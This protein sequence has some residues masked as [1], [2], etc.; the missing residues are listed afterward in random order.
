MCHPIRHDD[1]RGGL[2]CLPEN[3]V[4]HLDLCQMSIWVGLLEPSCQASP[5]V[6]IEIAEEGLPDV[7]M[8]LDNPRQPRLNPTG[9][10]QSETEVLQDEG[11]NHRLVWVDRGSEPLDTEVC[12]ADQT[13]V[14]EIS[15]VPRLTIDDAATSHGVPAGASASSLRRPA[16]AS[17]SRRSPSFRASA[18]AARTGSPSTSSCS[19]RS[20]SRGRERARDDFGELPLHGHLLA[21]VAVDEHRLQRPVARERANLVE[22][23]AGLLPADDR[24]RNGRVAQRVTPHAHAGALAELRHQAQLRS[25]VQASGTVPAP[26]SRPTNEQRP[27][28]GAAAVGEVPAQRGDD[29]CRQRDELALASAVPGRGGSSERRQRRLIMGDSV[30]LLSGE[31]AATS[32]IRPIVRSVTAGLATDSL[33]AS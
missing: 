8:Q 26:T 7:I 3:Q 29:G 25:R 2:P 16:A 4:E 17:T 28:A 15:P 11:V 24:L 13:G 12:P 33:G 22:A 30:N 9:A 21:L 1:W 18:R 5:H 10:R 31:R 23:E 19:S 32:L 14:S 6:G 20:P 27:L